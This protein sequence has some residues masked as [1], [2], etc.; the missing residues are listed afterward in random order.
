[1]AGLHESDEYA[2]RQPQSQKTQVG[3]YFLAPAFLPSHQ[4]DS[5]SAVLAGGDNDK[6]RD[7]K[8]GLRRGTIMGNMGNASH[9]GCDL[10]TEKLSAYQDGELDAEQTRLVAAHVGKCARCADIFDAIR[11]TDE[12]LEREWR[13]SAPLPSSLQFMQAVDNVMAALPPVPVQTPAFTP[14]RIHARA[15]WMRFAT[16]MAG[17]VILF[18]SLWSSYQI[19]YAHGRRSATSHSAS[20]SSLAPLEPQPQKLFPAANGLARSLSLHSTSR[21]IPAALW[22]PLA[23]GLPASR[24][25][26]VSSAL[27]SRPPLRHPASRP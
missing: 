1:M 4:P 17:V 13:D 25:A 7:N 24:R 10:V 22:L 16:G 14:R 18:A 21:L 9:E 19:G 15:R 12:T 20:Y 6:N 5:P 3:D 26:A 23:P 2:G 8:E 11:A 27:P